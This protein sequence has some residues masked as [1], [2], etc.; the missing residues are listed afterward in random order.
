MDLQR[1]EQLGQK[2]EALLAR[3][4]EL[5]RTRT[6]LGQALRAKEDE[7]A[8]LKD[9]LAEFELER[10]QVRQRLDVLLGRIDQ[11]VAEEN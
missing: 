6:Q 10:E 7:L 3:V 4:E 2:L 5:N 8:Q 11:Y 1:F 9:R